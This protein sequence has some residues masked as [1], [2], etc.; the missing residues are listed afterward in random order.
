MRTGVNA[1]AIII[2]KYINSAYDTVKLVADNIYHIINSSS[3]V[4]SYIVAATP[5]TTRV[6]GSPLEEG[7]RWF[8]TTV[9]VSYVYSNNAWKPEGTNTTLVETFTT[10]E[11]QTVFNLNNPYTADTN[12][13]LVLIN[14]VTQLSKSVSP[15]LGAYT[16][17]TNTSITFDTELPVGTQVTCIVGTIVTESSTALSIVRELYIATGGES[18]ITIPNGGEYTLGNNSLFVSVNGSEQFLSTGAYSETN[19][20]QITFSSPLNTGDI[21]LFSIIKLN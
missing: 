7:D 19:T 9:D 13:L 1:P 18:V 2:D 16:E 11:G 10:T 12:N 6:D 17:T 14:G 8:N 15:S 5:P 21:V 20:T 3:L 4:G